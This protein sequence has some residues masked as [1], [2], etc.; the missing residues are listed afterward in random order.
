MPATFTIV[1]QDTYFQ[2]QLVS[3]CQQVL[4]FS[5]L[6]QSRERCEQGISELMDIATDREFHETLQDRYGHFSFVFRNRKHTLI[7]YSIPYR[8]S[9]ARDAA[10]VQ[11]QREATGEIWIEPAPAAESL[12]GCLAA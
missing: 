9:I 6:Y 11:L 7:A 12:A 4:L 1:P 8:S 5:R 2:F 10:L 3:S